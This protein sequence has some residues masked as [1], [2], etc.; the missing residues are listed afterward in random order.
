[1]TMVNSDDKFIGTPGCLWGLRHRWRYGRGTGSA[2]QPGHGRRSVCARYGWV[3]ND[4]D[5]SSLET[6]E[7]LLVPHNHTKYMLGA[8]LAYLERQPGLALEEAA[9]DLPLDFLQVKLL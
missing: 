4:A 3:G 1:L 2:T 6:Q 7:G 5:G 9:T 8:G